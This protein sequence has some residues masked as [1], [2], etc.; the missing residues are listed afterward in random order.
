MIRVIRSDYATRKMIKQI[1][2][3]LNIDDQATIDLWTVLTALRGPDNRDKELKMRTTSRIRGAI[4]LHQH[5]H[6][7]LVSRET[8]EPVPTPTTPTG[9]EPLDHFASHY[10]EAVDVLKQLRLISK[11]TPNA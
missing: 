2:E 11:G 10:N 1:V 8:P 9:W 7:F 6:G 4:G 3:F 5:Q